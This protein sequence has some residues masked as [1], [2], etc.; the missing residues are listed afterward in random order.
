MPWFGLERIA[1]ILLLSDEKKKVFYINE[2]QKISNAVDDQ[3]VLFYLGT[4]IKKMFISNK[5]ITI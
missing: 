2:N 4:L 3:W 1:F 5:Y